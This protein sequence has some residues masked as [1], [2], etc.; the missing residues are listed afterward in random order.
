MKSVEK[1]ARTVEEALELALIALG[2]T[3]EEV[4]VEVIERDSSGFLGLFGG[5]DAH[6]RVTL[7]EPK[8]DILADVFAPENIVMEELQELGIDIS[9]TVQQEQDP[10]EFLAEFLEDLLQKMYLDASVEV[11]DGVDGIEVTVDGEDMSLLIGRRGRTLD[12]LQY[13]TNL[14]FNRNRE[15]YI[16]VLVD[17]QNYRAK[18][19]ESLEQM[20]YRMAEKAK[21]QRK[22]IIL[23]P[24]NAYE[25]RIVHSAL[26][27]DPHVS[28]RSEGKDPH[29][30]IIIFLNR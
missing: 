1:H 23:N 8:E 11:R 27:K 30:K 28:T 19:K 21:R 2:A 6:I 26:Q 22:D 15:E 25:R 29:R 16:H 4:D 9:D 20:A 12:A 24:M 5:R 18:R 13:I 17:S 14:V 3:E 7:K 10:K